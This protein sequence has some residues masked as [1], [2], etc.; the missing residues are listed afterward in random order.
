M[1]SK[2]YDPFKDLVNNDFSKRVCID[3][4]DLEDDMEMID[5]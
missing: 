2:E 3:E 1:T 5:Q 4:M